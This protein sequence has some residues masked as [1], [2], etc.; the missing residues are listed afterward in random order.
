MYMAF[1]SEWNINVLK[2]HTNNFWV[3]FENVLHRMVTL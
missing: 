3:T 1:F 2:D